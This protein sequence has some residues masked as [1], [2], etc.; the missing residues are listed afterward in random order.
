MLKSLV[1]QAHT[2]WDS[3]KRR[4]KLGVLGPLCSHQGEQGEITP[5]R[6]LHAIR[7]D[8]CSFSG[9]RAAWEDELQQPAPTSYSWPACPSSSRFVL[10]RK[11]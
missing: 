1:G 11:V 8:L 4:D 6:V 2:L 3:V 5:D 9:F 10:I 7:S